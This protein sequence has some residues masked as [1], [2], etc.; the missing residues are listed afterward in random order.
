MQCFLCILN[1]VMCIFMTM[2]M[3]ILTDRPHANT[4]NSQC[5]QNLLLS[6]LYR[7]MLLLRDAYVT[8]V[9][10]SSICSRYPQ[11]AFYPKLVYYIDNALFRVRL[12]HVAVDFMIYKRNTKLKFLMVSEYLQGFTV[13]CVLSTVY[14]ICKVVTLGIITTLTFITT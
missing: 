6:I 2:G 9:R 11:E 14:I 5:F 13:L 1:E 7:N 8:R 4:L 10:V 12:L 3:M